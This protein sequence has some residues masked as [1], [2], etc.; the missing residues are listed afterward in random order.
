M[1]TR[2]SEALPSSDT[3]LLMD[4]SGLPLLASV[5]SSANVAGAGKQDARYTIV[6]GR[7]RCQHDLAD[8]SPAESVAER[9]EHCR[10]CH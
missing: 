7:A 10:C 4:Q 9:H 3:Y 5:S 6:L 8:Y 2:K 1:K